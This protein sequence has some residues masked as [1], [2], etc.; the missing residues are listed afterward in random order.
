MS[1]LKRPLANMMTVL[2]VLIVWTGDVGE[3]LFLFL[4]H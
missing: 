4:H 1:R 3:T 2:A